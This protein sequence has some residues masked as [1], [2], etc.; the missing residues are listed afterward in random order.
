VDLQRSF[1]VIAS[2]YEV[3]REAWHQQ[4]GGD[5]SFRLSKLESKASLQAS[6]I[7]RRASMRAP[8]KI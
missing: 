2:E 8:V 1:A 6:Q 7:R 3:A 4:Y 5:D